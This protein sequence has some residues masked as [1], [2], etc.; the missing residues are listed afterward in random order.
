[1]VGDLIAGESVDWAG[2]GISAALGAASGALAA[3]GFGVVTQ[4]AGGALLAGA[5][6]AI[7]QGRDKGFG[8]IDYGE[9]AVSAAIGGVSS[10]SNGISKATSNHLYKQAS[11]ATKRISN[12]I[13]YDT[14]RNVGKTALSAGK[15]YLS[16]TKSLFYALLLNDATESFVSSVNEAFFDRMITPVYY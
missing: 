12:S 4:I 6:N 14:L 8:N 1:M 9:V 5:E 15:Y 7:D 2:A 3:T 16:Q 11:V 13:K 10:R